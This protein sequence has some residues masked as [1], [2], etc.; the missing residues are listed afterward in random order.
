MRAFFFGASR[1]P[2]LFLGSVIYVA[3]GCAIA[4]QNF[5][6]THNAGNCCYD[7]AA[8]AANLDACRF[9]DTADRRGLFAHVNCNGVHRKSIQQRIGDFTR[10]RFQQVR[11]GVFDKMSY[12]LEHVRI[13]DR[14]LNQSLAPPRVK[15]VLDFNIYDNA[16]AH[17]ALFG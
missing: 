6:A 16:A 7:C 15:V 3:D 11:F 13:T 4:T 5:D 12:G 10:Q 9:D 2:G 17:D 14:I 1:A 8:L